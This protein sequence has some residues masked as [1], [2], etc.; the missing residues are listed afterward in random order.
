[1]ER[2]EDALL[3]GAVQVN[4][5]IPAGDEIE[6]RERWILDDVVMREQHHLP[7]LAL[8]TVPTRLA[9]KEAL[10]TLLGY[11]HDIGLGVEAFAGRG[12]RVFIE[13]GGEHLYVGR[14][15][16]AVEIFREQHADRVRLL[17]GGAPRNP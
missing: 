7:E 10:E 2:F 12:D 15:D 4:Q 14:L 5:Q 11:V 9:V 6:M 3:D 17:A 8:D 13:I 16:H 1:M